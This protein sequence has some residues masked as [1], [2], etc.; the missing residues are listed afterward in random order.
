MSTDKFWQSHRVPESLKVSD[1]NKSALFEQAFRQWGFDAQVLKLSEEASELA[2]ASAQFL[3]HKTNGKHLA[4]EAADVEIMIEQ[5]RH[6]GMSAPIDAEKD[7]KLARLALLLESCADIDAMPDIQALQQQLTETE[8]FYQEDH[9]ELCQALLEFDYFRASQYARRA[10]G[11]LM[12]IAQQL[13]RIG[14][15]R[16]TANPARTE[17]E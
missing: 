8:Y 11:R 9:D 14:R 7:R 17:A 16:A 6:N 13:D 4:E 3:N 10:A 12:H 1:T 2:V 5:L 15:H